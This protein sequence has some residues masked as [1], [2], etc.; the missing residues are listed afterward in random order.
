LL[1]KGQR[2]KNPVLILFEYFAIDIHTV[3]FT[4]CRLRCARPC[5]LALD[6][7]GR[8]AAVA[9]E[10]SEPLRKRGLA[11]VGGLGVRAK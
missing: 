7:T 11:A 9:Q 1:V 2:L 8:L 4:R 10:G 6:A 3:T 5:T